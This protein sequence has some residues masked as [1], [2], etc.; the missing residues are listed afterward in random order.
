MAIKAKGEAGLVCSSTALSRRE[1]A[2]VDVLEQGL[3]GTRLQSS[4]MEVTPLKSGR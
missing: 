4:A 3:P 2:S 1:G